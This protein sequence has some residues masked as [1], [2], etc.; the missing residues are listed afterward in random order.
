MRLVPI[1]D[2]SVFLD[3]ASATISASDWKILRRNL[4]KSGCPLSAITLG[5]L[6]TG[7]AKCLAEMFREAQQA[8]HLARSISKSRVLD[9]PRSFAWENILHEPS[10]YSGVDR[11]KLQTWLELA[12]RA[13]TKED[14]VESALPDK[15]TLRQGRRYVGLDLA[16]IAAD[17]SAEQS[18]YIRATQ[19]ALQ[20]MRSQTAENPTG[21]RIPPRPAEKLKFT[22]R[23]ADWN[24]KVAES[25]L[26]GSELEP[27]DE[28]LAALARHLDAAFT[29]ETALARQTFLGTYRFEDNPSDWFDCLQLY[30][31]ARPN[32]CFLT[33]DK[34]LLQRIEGCAQSD[35]VFTFDSFMAS[36]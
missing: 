19:R 35:R 5:E 11:R 32:Y 33:Q 17:T 25:F 23:R 3:A 31:L 1:L 28:R 18:R 24:R 30:Y 13:K 21:T 7:V 2:T 15:R 22:F 34:R 36:L 20:W 27:T 16:G 26:E 9:Q 29:L 8:L 12:C 4:P 14:L 10:P 6:L